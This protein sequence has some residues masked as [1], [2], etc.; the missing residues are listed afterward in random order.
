MKFMKILVWVKNSKLTEFR[1]QWNVQNFS[2]SFEKIF[3]IASSDTI[4]NSA[5]IHRITVFTHHDLK[6]KWVRFAEKT[7]I[8]TKKNEILYLDSLKFK[9]WIM[10]RFVGERVYSKEDARG[11]IIIRNKPAIIRKIEKSAFNQGPTDVRVR[12]FRPWVVFLLNSLKNT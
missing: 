5:E 10:S 8:K 12:K 2:I 3:D 4:R 7:G 9:L 1:F 11:E 6:S